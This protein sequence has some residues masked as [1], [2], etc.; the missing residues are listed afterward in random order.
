MSFVPVYRRNSA[1]ITEGPHRAAARAM[2]KASGFDDEALRKP[3]VGVAN[4]WIEIGPCNYHLR[5]LAERMTPEEEVNGSIHRGV[6]QHVENARGQEQRGGVSSPRRHE[7]EGDGRAEAD[8][9]SCPREA[10]EF[11]RER[12]RGRSEFRR[13]A[14]AERHEL[15]GAPA[16][17]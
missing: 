13:I 4:T 1:A 9:E 6:K 14:E 8:G 12:V 16:A 7:E 17:E 5:T 11:R 2:L 15:R 10:E 3:I